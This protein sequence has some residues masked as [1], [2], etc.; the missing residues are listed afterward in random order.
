MVPV[1]VLSVTAETM[2]SSALRMKDMTAPEQL[3]TGN[4]PYA[5]YISSATGHIGLAGASQIHAVEN[6]SLAVNS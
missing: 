2:G 5:E 4:T 6:V 3:Q 1:S